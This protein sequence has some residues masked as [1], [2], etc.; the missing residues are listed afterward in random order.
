MSELTAES[1]SGPAFAP[2][3]RN[4]M[5][6]QVADQIRRQIIE[7]KLKSGDQLPPERELASQFGVSRVTARQA[8][9]LLMA[10]GLIQNQ[11]GRG[12]F[13]RADLDGFT[14]SSLADS[15]LS[16]KKWQHEMQIR[17]LI[18][19]EAARLAAMAPGPM[20][21]ELEEN[22]ERQK[23]ALPDALTFCAEDTAFHTAIGKLTG[24]PLLV[25]II[26][27]LHTMTEPTR[28]ESL[29]SEA[30]RRRSLADH[31]RIL[32]AIRAG[33]PDAARTAMSDHLK[34][35]RTLL[36]RRDQ[37]PSHPDDSEAASD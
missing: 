8:L 20:I 3:R 4:R 10:E 33:E 18:E 37:S 24:N 28:I 13:L 34:S 36:D 27:I 11:V 26:E 17:E 15:V 12:T 30:G 5:Y 9:T 16:S 32:E 2:V 6:E 1:R 29:A 22:I 14:I 31:I 19:P 23:R 7:G 21:Q 25:R 35:V